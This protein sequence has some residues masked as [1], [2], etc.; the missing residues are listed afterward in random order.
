M[1]LLLLVSFFCIL[2]GKIL[3]YGQTLE[4]ELTAAGIAIIFPGDTKY[5]SARQA[6]ECEFILILSDRIDQIS[7]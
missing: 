3:V 5:T 1:T 4:R 7:R 2:C 6:C